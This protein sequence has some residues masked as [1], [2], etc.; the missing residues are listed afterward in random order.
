MPYAEGRSLSDVGWG[1]TNAFRLEDLSRL[2]SLLFDIYARPSYM[3]E[4]IVSLMS[5]RSVTT[6][7]DANAPRLSVMVGSDNYIVALASVL[8]IHFK[9]PGYGQDD[10]PIGGA[11]G[12]ELWRRPTTGQRYVRVFYQAQT[13]SQLRALSEGIPATISLIPSSCPA[14]KEGF[15][16]L[17]DVIPALERAAAHIR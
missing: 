15:C 9:M 3:A 10:P 14:S 6:L 8:G 7:Q 1:R 16:R 2:H 11:L 13:L 5:E 12:I 4:R 17:E